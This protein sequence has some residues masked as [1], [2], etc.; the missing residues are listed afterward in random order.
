MPKK[1]RSRAEEGENRKRRTYESRWFY[2]KKTGRKIGTLEPDLALK[3]L[4]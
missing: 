1:Y 2:I 4:F 3:S